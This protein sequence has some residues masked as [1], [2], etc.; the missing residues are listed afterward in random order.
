MT[1]NSG[2]SIVLCEL[3]ERESKAGNTYFT[4]FMGA[5]SV[6]L[7]RDGERPHPTRPDETITVWKLVAQERQP[8]DAAQKP[9]PRP[10]EREEAPGPP[11]PQ[12][13]RAPARVLGPPR[14]RS[15]A[16]AARAPGRG[17]RRCRPR[18]PPAS[19]CT[20]TGTWTIHCR[21]DG[22]LPARAGARQ[23]GAAETAPAIIG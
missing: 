11:G 7:L 4:G 21:S 10:P 14:C 22:R 9:P 1:Y 16:S 20:A 19:G 6:A 8:R 12:P 23:R 18:S 15:A 5:V 13:P 17:R 2:P 3:W